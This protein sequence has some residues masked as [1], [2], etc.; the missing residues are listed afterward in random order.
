[1]AH[2]RLMRQVVVH[3][4]VLDDDTPVAELDEPIPFTTPTR[5]FVVPHHAAPAKLK[6]LR[7]TCLFELSDERTGV[8]VFLVAS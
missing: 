2:V 3:D 7:D 5:T 6:E 4:M 1:M 8:S